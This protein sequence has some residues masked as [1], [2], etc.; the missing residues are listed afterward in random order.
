MSQFFSDK[1]LKYAGRTSPVVEQRD[2]PCASCGYNLRGLPAGSRCPE[3]GATNDSHGTPSSSSAG[4]TRRPLIDILASD[5]PALRSNWRISLSILVACLFGITGAQLVAFVAHL[6]GAGFIRE[7]AFCIACIVLA[8]AWGYGVARA[9]PRQIVMAWSWTRLLR[10]VV[11]ISQWLWLPACVL[12]AVRIFGSSSGGV[13]IVEI[14]LRIIAGIGV[15]G[16]CALLVH[17]AEEAEVEFAPDPINRAAWLLPIVT[18]IWLGLAAAFNTTL[19]GLVTGDPWSVIRIIFIM[20][21][22]VALAVWTWIMVR[23][24]QAVWRMR[25]HVDWVNR[26]LEESRQRE[27]RVAAKREAI[28][29]EVEAGIRATPLRE[30]ADLNVAAPRITPIELPGDAT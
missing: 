25:R 17:M 4:A 2:S 21:P 13:L 6:V 10:K 30:D 3:C 27:A 20:P 11:I 28:L 5:S 23:F 14:A 19:I 8:C 26:H 29:R 24:A 16:L 22:A 15:I 1:F 9:M 7:N 18:P 12:A